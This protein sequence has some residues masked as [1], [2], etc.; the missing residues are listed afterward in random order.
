MEES[1]LERLST[2]LDHRFAR[3]SLIAQALTHSGATG[4]QR[5]ASNERL[6][7]LGD[8]VL[9]L[10]LAELLMERFPL[11]DEGDLA[12]RYSK[13]VDRV[14]LAVVARAVGLGEYLSVSE[15]D[16]ARGMRDNPAVL[17]DACEAVIGALYLDGG[18]AAARGFIARMWAPLIAEFAE[19]PRDAKTSLQEWA[20]A[21]GLAPPLYV[22]IGRAGPPHRPEFTVEARVEGLP[23]GRAVG[24]SKRDA[25]QKAARAVLTVIAGTEDAND[26]G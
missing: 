6:E 2:R 24:A 25:E 14:S 21:R 11:E 4:G 10:L 23:P 13:L 12:R 1:G 8:R 20:Q 19:P 7:F 3:P 18:I 5:G 16:G 17:A 9:G 26:G 22:E 15:S